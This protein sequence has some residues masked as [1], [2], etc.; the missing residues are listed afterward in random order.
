M[1]A[2]IIH[3]HATWS[4]LYFKAA[5]WRYRVKWLQKNYTEHTANFVLLLLNIRDAR[6]EA[7][8]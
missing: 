3:E 8:L 5:C 2:V 6:I 7:I 1:I 4:S